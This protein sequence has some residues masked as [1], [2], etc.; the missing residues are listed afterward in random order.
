M[1]NATNCAIPHDFR[2]WGQVEARIY[3]ALGTWHRFFA[4]DS[5]PSLDLFRDDF[6]GFL[7]HISFLMARELDGKTMAK[8]A[9]AGKSSML[10]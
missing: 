8:V 9:L 4:P 10:P 3:G 5:T 6:P 7:K 2:T 1:G